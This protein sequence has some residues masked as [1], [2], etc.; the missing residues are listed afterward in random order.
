M[1][2]R[3]A[4]AV[5]MCDGMRESGTYVHVFPYPRYHLWTVD[6]LTGDAAV[7][8]N[9]V[10]AG[11]HRSWAAYTTT[12]PLSEQRGP[13][14][15][16]FPVGPVSPKVSPREGR[17]ARRRPARLLVHRVHCTEYRSRVLTEYIERILCT[18]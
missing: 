14:P 11:R 2:C 12:A 17:P 9:S 5:R 13:V 8:Y 7:N 16:W 1:A 4:E 10:I 18:L 15:P 6:G 3:L